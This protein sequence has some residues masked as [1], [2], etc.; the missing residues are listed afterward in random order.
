V[1]LYLGGVR[2]PEVTKIYLD[3]SLAHWA[4]HGFGLWVLR[5]LD[6]AFVGRAGLRHVEVEGAREIEIAYSLVRTHWGQGLATE[7]AG[8]L[9]NLWL[10]QL[11]SPSLVGVVAIGNTASCRVLEKCGFLSERPAVY[12]GAKVVVFRRTRQ[13]LS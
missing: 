3:V 5:T 9:T 6:G 10:T 7:I 4:E 2:P 13:V 11:R 12:H 1:S 8:A